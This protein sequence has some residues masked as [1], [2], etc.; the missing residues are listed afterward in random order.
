M[1]ATKIQLPDWSECL[2]RKDARHI[3]LWGGRGGAKSRSIGTALILQAAEEHH[4]VLCGREI[5]NSIRA[6]VKRL[7]DD[8]I[9]H[10]GLSHLFESTER[11]IRGP[12]DSLFIFAGLR[13]NASGIRSYEGLTDAWIEE[14]QAVSQASID[15][16]LAGAI[17][18][19]LRSAGVQKLEG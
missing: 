14:A 7:L 11:E 16:H 2:W 19:Q 13:G 12:N 3:A 1:L 8:E 6:S 17:P 9:R 18:A 5:Q 4:R 10:C 15:A